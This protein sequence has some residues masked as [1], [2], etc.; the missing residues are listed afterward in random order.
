MKRS[1]SV[2]NLTQYPLRR[3]EPDSRVA[4]FL[5][6]CLLAAGLFPAASTFG[7]ESSNWH[8]I[9]DIANVA[10]TFLLERAG[11]SSGNTS[12]Q[13]GMLDDRLQ[14]SACDQPLKGFLRPG[15]RIGPRTIV[16]VRCDGERPWRMYVPVQVVV[17]TSVW[18]ARHP[19][20]RGHLLT[21]DDL[22]ADVRD[23]SRMRS[24]YVSNLESLTGQR[25]RSSVLAGRVL[26]LQMLDENNVIQRGQ[27]VTLAVSGGG[28]NISMTGKALM[29]GALQQRIRVE[30]T[31]SGRIV[32]GIVRSR[33][34][35]EVLVPSGSSFLQASPKVSP[36]VADT[37]Y[38][39]NDR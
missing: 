20:P 32:E 14:L 11:R 38:S 12:V 39:N 27:T 34:L 2:S 21:P 26:T 15:T 25:L 17:E 33:E 23:V 36:A 24:G 31:N 28:I 13:A 30:N 29:D 19:L 3:R 5:R 37:G 1:K 8:D 9:A 6:A 18:V 10:E 22:V 16:G 4:R 35:V 7:G